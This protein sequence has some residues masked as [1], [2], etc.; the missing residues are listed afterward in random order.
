MHGSGK[1]KEI[2]RRVSFV[3]NAALVLIGLFAFFLAEAA[4]SRGIAVK[5]VTAL[6]A[7]AFPFCFLLYLR[8]RMRLRWTFWTAVLVC[9]AVHTLVIWIIFKYV[10]ADFTHFSPLLWL[11]FML[12]DSFGLMLIV[13]RIERILAGKSQ[14]I[15]LNF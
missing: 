10:L 1:N 6:F 8:R 5:W 15:R 3:E 14:V 13:A 11:P 12:I 2:K 9:L 4:H 7:T